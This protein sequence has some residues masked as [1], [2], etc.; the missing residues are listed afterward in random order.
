MDTAEGFEDG[1]G[2]GSTTALDA[3]LESDV[4]QVDGLSIVAGGINVGINV[5][6]DGSVVSFYLAL[7]ETFFNRF[8]AFN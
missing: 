4:G 6:F 8:F 5:G 7:T 2:D 3:A 1:S